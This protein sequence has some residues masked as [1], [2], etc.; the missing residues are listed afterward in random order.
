[1]KNFDEE[2]ILANL[3]LNLKGSKKKRDNWIEIARNC[4]QLTD[5]YGSAQIVAEKLGVSYEIV[6]SVLTL[7]TLPEEVQEIIAR[8]Q[9]L[10]DVGQRLSRIK[11]KETQI[12]VA[13]IIIGLSSHDARQVIQY[14]KKYPDASI[15]DFKRRLIGSKDKI[16]KINLIVVPFRE[17]N[18]AILKKISEKQKTSPEKLIREIVDQWIE[19]K[20]TV[21]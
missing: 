20:K 4:R 12:K 8:N 19:K 3:Y 6:R 18:F 11:N 1:M 14:T 15:D 2:K 10:F 5:Y 16:E 21:G 13:K 17:E 7:L 9:I